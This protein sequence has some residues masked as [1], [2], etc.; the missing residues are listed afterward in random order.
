MLGNAH[1][2]RAAE[3]SLQRL[4]DFLEM[5]QRQPD[6]LAAG[7]DDAVRIEQ[8]KSRQRHV[9]GRDQVRHHARAECGEGRIGRRRRRPGFRPR[10]QNVVV[11][12]FQPRPDRLVGFGG[13]CLRDRRNPGA[14]GDALRNSGFDFAAKDRAER[15]AL[16]DQLGLGLLDQ[17]GLVDLEKNRLNSGIE[18]TLV[19]TTK[20]IRLRLGRHFLRGPGAALADVGQRD[21]PQRPSLKPTP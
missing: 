2:Q 15:G 18:S 10:R 14:E 12:K 1:A 5:R 7:D 21:A 6:F 19:R 16:R 4:G 13:R 9:L 20:T 17:L 8:P 3:M 11:L